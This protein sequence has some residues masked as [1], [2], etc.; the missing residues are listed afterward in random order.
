[1]MLGQVY[2]VAGRLEKAEASYL[3]SLELYP[4]LVQSKWQLGNLAFFAGEYER[5]LVY[6]QEVER[7][8]PGLS[9]VRE[10]VEWLCAKRGGCR[11]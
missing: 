8:E 9:G 11:E 2:Q 10:R 7:L 3:E 5:A 1:M 6:Y 4:D